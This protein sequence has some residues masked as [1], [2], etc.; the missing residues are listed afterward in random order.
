FWNEREAARRE[1]LENQATFATSAGPPDPRYVTIAPNWPNLWTGLSGLVGQAK[2]AANDLRTELRAMSLPVREDDAF[3]VVRGAPSRDAASLMERRDIQDLVLAELGGERPRVVRPRGSTVDESHPWKGEGY[4]EAA[5]NRPAYLE[6]G[7]GLLTGPGRLVVEL[8]PP[9]RQEP[10]F[11]LVAWAR[12]EGEDGLTERRDLEGEG[13]SSPLTA[14]FGGFGGSCRRVL[15]GLRFVAQPGL[16]R[17]VEPGRKAPG[18]VAYRVTWAPEEEAIADERGG[19]SVDESG[20]SAEPPAQAPSDAPT[21]R[22]IRRSKETTHRDPRSTVHRKWEWDFGDGAGVEDPDPTHTTTTQ[23]HAY[24]PGTYTAAARS[25]DQNGAVIRQVTWTFTVPEEE[26]G[27]PREF[28]ADTIREPR[29]KIVIDGPKMWVT[30]KPAE[31]RVTAEVDDPPYSENKV[32]SIDPG[33]IFFVIW[34]RPGTFDVSAAVTVRLSYRFPERSVFV[35]DTYVE[36]VEVQ[37]GATAG[38]E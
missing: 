36:K 4:L 10:G 25:I 29:V 5:A 33:P 8:S 19:D 21:I 24:A 11:T 16:E 2:P 27:R 1:T 15:V 23:S 26:A 37:V 7:D 30:G 35:V 28:K 18:R 38:T 14:D 17:V 32:V 34:E 31:F 13:P 22:V 20:D 6:I 9:S 12:A 3:I